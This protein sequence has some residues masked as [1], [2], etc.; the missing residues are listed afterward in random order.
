VFSKSVR[1]TTFSAYAQM[2]VGMLC[3]LLLVRIATRSLT[4]EEFGLWSFVFGSIGYFLMLDFGLSYSLGRIFAD[5]IYSGDGKA[6][7]GKFI[8]ALIVLLGQ[9]ILIAVLGIMLCEP[10]LHYFKI[11]SVL[12]EEARRLWIWCILIQAS[13]LPLRI[14]P[15]IIHAQNRVY[16][17]NIISAVSQVANLVI[18]WHFITH[19]SGVMAYAYASLLST[20]LIY[21]GYILCVFPGK[22]PLRLTLVWPDF[23]ELPSIMKYAFSILAAMITTQASGAAQIMILTRLLGLDAVAIYSVSSRVPMLLSSL[24]IK[25]FE[26]HR[27][28]WIGLYCQKETGRMLFSIR[29][30]LQ[31][32]LILILVAITIS[33]IINPIFVKYWTRSDYYAG[34]FFNAL[35]PFAFMGAALGSQLNIL[36]HITKKMRFYTIVTIAGALTEILLSIILVRKIGICGVPVATIMCTGGFVVVFNLIYGR[37]QLKQAVS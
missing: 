13:S 10:L 15:A 28:E 24:C 21:I 26:A 35:I 37:H 20:T 8:L 2:G 27:M 34:T 9:A 25:P 19:G 36:F 5:P 30:A 31:L 11:S 4:P 18:F 33:I 16:L 7:S 6:L 32:A 1:L 3:S 22:N 17:A 12:R 23:S 14:F 29:K